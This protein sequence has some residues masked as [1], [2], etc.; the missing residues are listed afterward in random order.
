M[1]HGREVWLSHQPH[2]LK[3]ASSNLAPA[4]KASIGEVV[5]NSKLTS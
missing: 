5:R 1:S 3:I 4:S 2:E